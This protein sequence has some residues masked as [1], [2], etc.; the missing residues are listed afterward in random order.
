M[1]LFPSDIFTNCCDD[2]DVPEIYPRYTPDFSI[3]ACMLI[4]GS[5]SY[6]MQTVILVLGR[7]LESVI[8][9]VILFERYTLNDERKGSARIVRQED[10]ARSG[11]MAKPRNYLDLELRSTLILVSVGS[12][13]HDVWGR[14]KM[15]L[16]SILGMVISFGIITGIPRLRQ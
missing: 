16:G 9:F 3:P 15:L 11:D 1:V 6:K 12:R 13:F 7:F 8:R 4:F 14:R 2:C 10:L 5:I